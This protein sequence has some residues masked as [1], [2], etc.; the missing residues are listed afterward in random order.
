[1]SGSVVFVWFGSK[2]VKATLT[3]KRLLK[4]LDVIFIAV[5]L[6]AYVA[7]LMAQDEAD[8]A[9]NVT[10]ERLPEEDFCRLLSDQDAIEQDSRALLVFNQQ[11]RTV[12]IQGLR[13]S[14]LLAQAL[15]Q[16]KVGAH[17]GV[18]P[19]ASGQHHLVVAVR[20]TSSE[21]DE[22]LVGGVGSGLG[23]GMTQSFSP[24][25]ES[26]HDSCYDSDG[27][28]SGSRR[29]SYARLNA[30]S[31]DDVSRT[32]SDTLAAEH[33]EDDQPL[34]AGSSRLH[35]DCASS[36]RHRLL[37][38]TSSL[39]ASIE[40]QNTRHDISSAQISAKCASETHLQHHGDT[41]TEHA[42]ITDLNRQVDDTSRQLPPDPTGQGQE[43]KVSSPET[44]SSEEFAQSAAYT[45]KV[46]FAL[47][48]GYSEEQLREVLHRC[49]RDLSQ[50]ELL[51]Q[52]IQLGSNPGQGKYTK[53][54]DPSESDES[55]IAAAAMVETLY[56]RHPGDVGTSRE[57]RELVVVAAS[58]PEPM[59]DTGGNAFLSALL[60]PQAKYQDGRPA[61]TAPGAAVSSARDESNLRQIVIDG[62]N[63]AMR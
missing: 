8:G 14:V 33:A 24:G 15:L 22:R 19:S 49:G 45:P 12:C 63:V 52:L 9:V 27:S 23:G 36:P 1:M 56:M 48:L 35:P 28:T 53:A 39:P 6:Q 43:S 20:S 3:V 31:H 17:P 10:T 62:S 34:G 55:G 61:A 58:E 13:P 18:T 41:K 42:H 47:K 50:N 57:P 16:R 29:S 40:A 30:A 51:S 4:L 26:S 46:E 54:P 25:A 32:V 7:S 37:N 44:D 59:D 11:E 60:G 38:P 2:T 21:E 5:Y